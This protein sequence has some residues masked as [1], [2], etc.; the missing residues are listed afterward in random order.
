MVRKHFKGTF[1]EC[2]TIGTIM[3]AA[4]IAKQTAFFTNSN[5]FTVLYGTN[6]QADLDAADAMP[7]IS[8]RRGNNEVTREELEALNDEI[9]TI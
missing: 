7:E 6:L 1:G 8:I 4:Y 9:C 2:K 3:I 5:A